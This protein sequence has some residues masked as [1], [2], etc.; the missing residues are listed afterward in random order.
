MIIWIQWLATFMFCGSILNELHSIVFL[1]LDH[2][3]EFWDSWQVLYLI[4]LLQSF[5]YVREASI[6]L[7]ETFYA[8]NIPPHKKYLAIDF[9]HCGTGKD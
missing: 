2:S 3:N 1:H 9:M 7:I 6:L 4:K 8:L 5:M